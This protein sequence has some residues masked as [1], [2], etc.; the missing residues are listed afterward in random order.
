[1][2]GFEPLAA[3]E[4]A[5]AAVF[6]LITSEKVTIRALDAVPSTQKTL[7]VSDKT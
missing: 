6:M 3:K 2:D 5:E 4:V 7:Q 1:V